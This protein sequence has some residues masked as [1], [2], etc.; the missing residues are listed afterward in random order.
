MKR[1]S[2]PV[3]LMVLL[4]VAFLLLMTLRRWTIID[5]AWLDLLFLSAGLALGLSLNVIDEKVLRAYYDAERQ[6]GLITRSI[7]FVAAC[8]PLSILMITSSAS[9]MGGGLVVG[10][11]LSTLMGMSHLVQESEQFDAQYMSQL[12]RPLLA[13][14]RQV[15]VGCIALWNVLLW[16]AMLR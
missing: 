3:M 15:L 10:I 11:A 8:I 6:E 14:E 1:L 7:L 16:I 9:Y 5:Q 2:Q 4:A 12:K 13:W